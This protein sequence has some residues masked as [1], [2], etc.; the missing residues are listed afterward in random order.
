MA[1]WGGLFFFTYVECCAAMSAVRS[2][3][4]MTSTSTTYATSDAPDPDGAQ[5]LPF[6]QRSPVIP[7]VTLASVADA[8][9]LAR[10]LSAGGIGIV[11][12]TFRSD[13]AVGGIAAIRAECPAIAVG[14]G[15]VWTAQQALQAANAGAQFVVSPGIADDVHDVARAKRLPYLPGAQTAS[16]AAHLVRRGLSA[17]KF[18]P[19]A[20][21]GGPAAVGAL[22]AVFPDLTFCPTG[23]VNETNAP[24]YLKLPCVPC[25]GGTWLTPAALVASRRWDEIEA[26]AWRATALAAPRSAAAAPS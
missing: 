9:P 8:V 10:A 15:T 4:G 22:A 12:I 18:F 24:E 17:L 20:P 6:L 1:T 14:A 19:A 5:M 3:A 11:E 7:V 23:G 13:A 21:A 25:V 16:E 26:L 2:S